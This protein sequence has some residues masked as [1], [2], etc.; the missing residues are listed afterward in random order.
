M[1]KASPSP[2]SPTASTLEAQRPATLAGYPSTAAVANPFSCRG[3]FAACMTDHV[4]A[5]PALVE[6][7][8][9]HVALD[10]TRAALK[11]EISRRTSGVAS[12][13]TMIGMHLTT[14]V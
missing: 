14:D 13:S 3:S 6:S 8:A 12:S 4:Q 2:L 11:P 10:M 1:N 9:C 7:S 5:C